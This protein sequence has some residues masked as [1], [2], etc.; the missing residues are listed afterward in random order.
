MEKLISSTGYGF[1]GSTAITDLVREYSEVATCKSSGYELKFFHD[2]KGILN[3][4]HYMI[5]NRTPAAMNQA[6]RDYIE[7]CNQW[8]TSGSSM[9][10]EI[11]FDN[12]FLKYTKEYVESLCGEK[13]MLIHDFSKMTEGQ[14]IIYR[15]L[16]KI[17][18]MCHSLTYKEA[19]GQKHLKPLTIFSQKEKNCIINLKD[20]DFVNITKKYFANL[21]NSFTDKP[22]ANL[23]ELIPISLIDE[24]SR[25]FDNLYVITTERDPRD[26]Y[27]NA[28]YR[29]LTLDHPS[30]NVDFFCEYYRWIRSLIPRTEKKEV[31]K[32]QFEDLVFHYEDTVE[33][34]EDFLGFEAKNHIYPKKYFVPEKAALNC[35]LKNVYREEKKN[36]QII[37]KELSE[38]LY[39]FEI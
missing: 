39:D 12:K 25:Y 21:L 27:L 16:S 33:K 29:W 20:E 3:L 18:S 34:I 11:F 30:Q 38:W 15:L 23:H 7:R 28:K 14:K 35:N 31:L 17:N 1:T 36:I 32:I 6:R 24:C 26:I 10:Y 5:V 8:A 37:E 19:Y 2:T 22:Y 9:N 13:Y 4:Y